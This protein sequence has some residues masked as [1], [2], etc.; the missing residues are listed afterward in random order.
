[1]TDDIDNGSSNYPVLSPSGDGSDV[2]AAF[3]A[4]STRTNISTGEKLGVIFGKIAKWFTDLGDAAFRGVDSTVTA[5]STNLV[6][7]GAVKSAIDA[8]VPLRIET[9]P[10]SS[11]QS[12]GAIYCL[13]GNTGIPVG[14]KIVSSDPVQVGG[15]FV[16]GGDNNWY[17]MCKNPDGTKLVPTAITIKTIY[18]PAKY[19]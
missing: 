5:S 3:T 4:A 17:W 15:F 8:L 13:N 7:S 6:E 12:N 11:P 19:L 14:I 1:M 2:T 18:V 9:L 16:R 10:A